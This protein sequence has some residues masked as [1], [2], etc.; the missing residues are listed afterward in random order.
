M[1]A[2]AERPQD[3]EQAPEQEPRSKP[4][5]SPAEVRATVVGFLAGLVRWAGLAFAIVLVVHVLLTVGKANPDNGITVFFAHA[6]DPLALAFRSLFTP[7]NAELRVLV[8]YGLAALFW[9]IV[10]SVI[11]RLIRRLA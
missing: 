8:N 10:S 1:A 11:S 9:L 7:A 6:A 5:R 2:K 3:V 4:R